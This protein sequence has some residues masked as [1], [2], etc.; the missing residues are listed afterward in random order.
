MNFTCAEKHYLTIVCKKEFKDNNFSFK[1][2]LILNLILFFNIKSEFKF[3]NWFFAVLYL[4]I[5]LNCHYLSNELT[6][7]MDVLDIHLRKK[8]TSE[9]TEKCSDLVV[10]KM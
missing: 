9:N 8:L 2:F 3:E 1:I 7:E 5:V 4:K 6:I 10:G